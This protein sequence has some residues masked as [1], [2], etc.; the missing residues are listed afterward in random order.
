MLAREIF[1]TPV[2]GFYCCLPAPV[3]YVSVYLCMRAAGEHH[4]FFFFIFIFLFLLFQI[5]FLEA[6]VAFLRTE[7]NSVVAKSVRGGGETV[8]SFGKLLV[9]LL[10]DLSP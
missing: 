1:N 6:L 10:N 5:G 4:L 2:Q 9:R 8:S 3:M 7:L